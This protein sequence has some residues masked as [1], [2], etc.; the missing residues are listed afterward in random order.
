MFL[1]DS[2]KKIL[3]PGLNY[4]TLADLVYIYNMYITIIVFIWSLFQTKAYLSAEA[5]SRAADQA[6]VAGS[7][8]NMFFVVTL[9]FFVAG[10]IVFY[11]TC[12]SRVNR[13]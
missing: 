13:A 12:K 2:Y 5:I 3:P 11:R 6:Q 8:D 7:L 10:P 9:L 1:Q 4:P